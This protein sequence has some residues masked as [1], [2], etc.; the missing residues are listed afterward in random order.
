[1]TEVF[2]AP[3]PRHRRSLALLTLVTIQFVGADSHA[4]AIPRPRVVRGS[5]RRILNSIEVSLGRMR[6]LRAW[7]VISEV[8]LD[9][10]TAA[11]VLPIFTHY[12]DRDLALVAQ[13]RDTACELRSLLAVPRPADTHI[14]RALDRL[15]ANQ[16]RR[17]ALHD[18]RLNELRG[19]LP[20]VQQARLVL[21]L[22]RIERD[23]VHWARK[24]IGDDPDL[25]DLV[26]RGEGGGRST[27]ART[28]KR[29]RP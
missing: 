28:T 8:R 27:G 14:A 29:A 9:E 7:R 1:M 21:L 23:F 10:A 19:V 6:A 13:R 25:C 20:P 15:A 24:A 22:P 5:E 3:L 4:D 12:D 16:Q 11:R 17:H 2:G 26:S 18:E